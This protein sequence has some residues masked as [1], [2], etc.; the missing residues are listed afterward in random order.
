MPLTVK[1]I[2]DA[3]PRDKQYK[4]TDRDVAADLRGALKAPTHGSFAAIGARPEQ[5]QRSL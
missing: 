4:L 2:R 5:H 3:E 1:D